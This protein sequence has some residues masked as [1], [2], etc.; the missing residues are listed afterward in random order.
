MPRD[1]RSYD[2]R[3]DG[4]VG[5]VPHSSAGQGRGRLV[6]PAAATATAAVVLLV[7]GLTVPAS[8]IAQPD[9]PTASGT[10]R[11]AYGCCALALSGH[12]P[13]IAQ[14]WRGGDRLAIHGTP[15]TGTIGRAASFGCLRARDEDARFVVRRAWLG[16]IV[17]IRQ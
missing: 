13:H 12:Q 15:L 3:E 16:T 14:G 10:V 9:P 8:D 6:P 2:R 1:A 5:R 4:Y 7:A 17:R 11:S